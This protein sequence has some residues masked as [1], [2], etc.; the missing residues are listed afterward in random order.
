MNSRW[1]ADQDD[2]TG[3]G[4]D[5]YSYQQ[6]QQ[7]FPLHDYTNC[8]PRNVNRSVPAHGQYFLQVSPEWQA[9]ALQQRSIPYLPGRALK[10]FFEIS[11]L[12]V[13]A[14]LIK[15]QQKK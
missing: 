6:K 13:A 5:R 12:I 14:G 7:E 8:R 11:A 10:R 1:S 4:Q 2:N 9:A 3:T 15:E